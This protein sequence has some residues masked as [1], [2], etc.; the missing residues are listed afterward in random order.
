MWELRRNIMPKVTRSLRSRVQITNQA[1]WGLIHG[2][3]TLFE[4]GCSNQTHNAPPVGGLQWAPSLLGLIY[5][6]DTS[7]LG[8]MSRPPPAK[9]S[10]FPG[11]NS[12]GLSKEPATPQSLPARE[13]VGF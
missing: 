8:L 9:R 11:G 6:M 2:N 5:P 1:L 7:L 12:P 10:Q 13:G 4:P 3:K